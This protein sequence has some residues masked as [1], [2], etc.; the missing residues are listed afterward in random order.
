MKLTIIHPCIGRRAGDASYIRTWQME[1]LPAAAI[2]GLTPRDVE[3]RFYD[4]RMEKIPFDEPA[5]LVA[6]SV[7]TYT[8]KRAYQIASAYRKRKVPVVMGGFH[9]SLQPEEVGRYAESVVVGEAESLWPNVIDDARH[10]RLA[11]TYHQK[12]RPA[13]AGMNPDR[14]IFRGKRYLPIG[15][16]EAGRGCHFKC[17]FC[18]VQTVFGATQTRRP[19]DD[20]LR[21]VD[22]VKHEKKLFFFVDDNITSNLD[23]AKE[24]FRALIPLK[25]RWVSQSSINAAH[26]EE[27]LDLLVRSGCMG[28]LIGFE[29]LDR[30]NLKD[31]NKLF[32][33]MR[34]GFAQ[35]LANL[36]RHRVRVYGTFIFGYD[37]DTPDS[38]SQTVAFAKEHAMYIAAFNHLTPFPGTPLYHRFQ[39]EGRLLY[40]AWWLDDRYRYNHIPFTPAGMSPIELQ[41]CCLE[42]RRAFYSWRS[43][44]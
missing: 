15:L 3:V 25:V 12:G 26:D 16:V 38:F 30:N 31:M 24:F 37:R 5:D 29:S 43:I 40:D 17:E 8:A 42:A 11:K 22:R 35:A 19:I 44:V 27:F 33:T 23:Q 7:E 9:A 20:I 2:A 4:D 21:E 10:G 34:G 36:R 28:V 14:S 39:T 6:I 13:L 1:P 18:A 32:N 41:R